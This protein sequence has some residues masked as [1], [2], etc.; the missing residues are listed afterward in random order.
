MV[1]YSSDQGLDV[2]REARAS[3]TADIDTVQSTR[4]YRVTSISVVAPQDVA[5]LADTG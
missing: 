4:R 2:M 5:V 3:H 1:D